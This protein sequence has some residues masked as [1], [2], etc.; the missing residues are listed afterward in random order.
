MYLL[1]L[2]KNFFCPIICFISIISAFPAIDQEK[3]NTHQ[4]RYTI[5]R[6]IHYSF[7]LKNNTSKLIEKAQFWTYA[8]AKQTPTQKCIHIEISHPHER[9]IDELGNQILYFVVENMPPYA[10]R[11]ISIRA[12]L[13]MAES[14]NPVGDVNLKPFLRCEKFIE[15]NDSRIVTQVINLKVSDPEKTAQTTALAVTK[16]FREPYCLGLCMGGTIYKMFF[17]S[18]FTKLDCDNQPTT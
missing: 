15:C 18:A 13:M 5:P 8:P 7:T 2:K 6:Q 14:P 12:S 16:N 4:G 17:C 1:P 3:K 9:I 11:M 10:G